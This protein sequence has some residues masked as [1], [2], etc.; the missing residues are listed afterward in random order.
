MRKLC[1]NHDRD[2]GLETVLEV[3]IPEGMFALSGHKA[4]YKSSWQ[5]MKAWMRP[6]NDKSSAPHVMASLFRDG[7]SSEVQMML[8][9]AGAPLIPLPISCVYDPGIAASDVKDRPI[10]ASMAR[11]IVQQYIAASGGEH[12]LDSITS[13]YAVGKVRMTTSE[14]CDGEDGFIDLDKNSHKL[15]SKHKNKGRH[16]PGKGEGRRTGL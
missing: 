8:G 16:H 3:P 5:M 10:E 1:P 6:R 9:V 13:M 4:M 12:A 2:D 7:K 14:F 15:A 11:Y